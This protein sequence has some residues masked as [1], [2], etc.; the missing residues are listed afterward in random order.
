MPTGPP[1]L[2]PRRSSFYNIYR[3]GDPKEAVKVTADAGF[4]A[5]AQWL[6]TQQAAVEKEFKASELGSAPPSRPTPRETNRGS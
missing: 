3:D 4:G 2:L 5:L 6:A 1:P